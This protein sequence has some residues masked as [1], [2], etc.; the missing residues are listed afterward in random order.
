M[1]R[2]VLAIALLAGPTIGSI[3]WIPAADR[4]SQ[5]VGWSLLLVTIVIA[6]ILGV[7]ELSGRSD[8]NAVRSR[9]GY[10]ECLLGADG[11]I[12]T[13]KTAVAAWTLVF[14]AALTLL[15][16]MVWF[17]DL[18]AEA[19]FG[20][21]WDSYFLLLGGP[22]AA[23]VLAKGITVGRLSNDPSAKSSTSAASATA[24]PTAQQ[25]PDNGATPIDIVANDAG[26]TDLID[27][28]YSLFTLVAVVYFVGALVNNLVSYTH[29]PAGA[30]GTVG[31]PEIPSAL[32]GLTSA[33]ALTYVGN[34]AVQTSG[35]R[36]VDLTPNPVQA[37]A[38]VSVRLVNLPATA[39]T[40]NTVVLLVA[41]GG[42]PTNL[43]PSAVTVGANPSVTFAAPAAGTYEV[44]IVAPGTTA[45]P[46]PLTVT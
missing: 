8:P 33:A 41:P 20:S 17:A 21:D 11:R 28:Q 6:A 32:L 23:A 26:E 19:A 44:S 29:L 9:V 31:L 13:S 24:L 5:K 15:S 43:A 45:G 3:A 25:V 39:S 37:G 10:L 22:F 2:L 38:A 46:L 18:S 27:T 42:A 34:K 14:V 1:K 7:L 40:Q 16:G 12:S 4:A 35:L 30:A 36:V